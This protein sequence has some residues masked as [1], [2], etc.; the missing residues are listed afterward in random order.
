MKFSISADVLVVYKTI[1]QRG[2]TKR[3]ERQKMKALLFAIHPEHAEN[4]YIKEF[5]RGAKR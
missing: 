3:K 2:K 5:G 4:G 1:N